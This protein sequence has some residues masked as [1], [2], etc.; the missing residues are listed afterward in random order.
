M[1][2]NKIREIEGVLGAAGRQNKYRFAFAWPKGIQGVSDLKEVDVLAKSTT[3]PERELGTIDLWN[4]G[5]KHVIPGD[6]AFSNTWT[7]DFYLGESHEIRYDMIKWQVACDN[8]HRNIHSGNP[9][10]IFSDLRVEQLDSAM[11]VTA[12]Y[13]LH[14]CFPTSVGE[15]S[16]SDDAEN[17][18]TEFSVTFSYTD[19]VLG[20]G[21]EDA[22]QPI[23]PTRN[24]TALANV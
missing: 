1:A 7:V 9:S 20:S 5:R 3:A 24:D 19:F 23:E 11:K 15:V 16:Y 22:W 4:Q 13:T 8:F 17:S 10:A 2:T 12:Q 18:V 14:N 21:E 6:T